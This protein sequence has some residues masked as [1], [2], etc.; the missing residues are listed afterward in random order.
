MRHCAKFHQNQLKGCRATAFNSFP[1][2]GHQ[3]SCM[4]F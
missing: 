2:G 4:D 3:P 1:N